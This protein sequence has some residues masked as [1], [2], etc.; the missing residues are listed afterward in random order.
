MERHALLVSLG[1]SVFAGVFVGV[2]LELLDQSAPVA[3]T[4]RF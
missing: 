4:C 1:Y 2:D 3:T